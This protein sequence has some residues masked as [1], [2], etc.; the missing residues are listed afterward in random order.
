MLSGSRCGVH[1]VFLSCIVERDRKKKEKKSIRDEARTYTRG[2]TTDCLTVSPS[3]SP[4]TPLP[5]RRTERE[6]DVEEYR[7]LVN[8]DGMTDNSAG[9]SFTWWW[10]CS[11]LFFILDV[12][13]L[14]PVLLSLAIS[15]STDPRHATYTLHAF[16]ITIHGSELVQLYLDYRSQIMTKKGRM[17]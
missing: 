5:D 3:V 12:L 2:K 1:A 10:I 16:S 7:R 9:R 4:A 17:A 8:L 15:R 13:S 11:R 6:T 14:A